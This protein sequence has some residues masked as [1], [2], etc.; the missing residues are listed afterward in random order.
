VEAKL[1]ISKRIFLLFLLLLFKCSRPLASFL[2]EES[3]LGDLGTVVITG[4]RIPRPV[5]L[6]LRNVSIIDG[7]EINSSP[8]YSVTE[9]LKYAP[10]VDLRERDPYGGQADLDVKGATFQQ[11]LILLDGVRMNDP[12]TGQHNLDLPINLEDLERI[13]VFHVQG[14]Y[15]YG[16]DAFGGVVNFITRLQSTER[17]VLRLSSVKTEQEVGLFPSLIGLGILVLVS[18]WE[19]RCSM[20]TVLIPIL[21]TSP[22][23]VILH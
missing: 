23:P 1:K 4:T 8:V 6:I 19:G 9:V 3:H 18:L 10:G 21:N 17:Q 5:S 16:A 14:S 22:F 15:L 13:E 12:Q 7:D 2:E 11:V 20:V